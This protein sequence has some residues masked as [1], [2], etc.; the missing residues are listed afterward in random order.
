MR[1]VFIQGGGIGVDQEAAVRR[2]VAAAGA[3]IDW[4]T[5]HAGRAAVERGEPPLP[6]RLAD[7]VRSCGFALKTKLLD[8]P[9]HSGARANVQLRRELGLFASVRPLVSYA[10]L[11][12]RF[13][14]IDMLV[15]REITEDLYSAIEHEI[16][17]GVVQSIKVVTEA[18]CLRFFRFVFALARQRGRQSVH[19]IHKA[20]ILK[21][22][23]GLILDCFRRVAAEHPEIRPKELIVDNACMQLV[24][25]PQQFEVM[26]AGNLYGDLLSDLGAGLVG[27][28]AA[29]YGINH[30]DGVRVYESIHGGTIEVV[31]ADKANPLPLLLSAVELLRDL[32]QTG[33]ADRVKAAVQAVLAAGRVRTADLGGTAGTHDFTDA[34]I[35]ALG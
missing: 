5:I 18:A 29:S 23:D 17:P 22:A 11:P 34:V 3:E 8:A 13:P 2:V 20:N 35:A 10:G 1:V 27:G 30:G 31:G 16:V 7:A 6:P 4:L 24:S 25:R 19:C 21:K 33:P 32:G 14:D 28:V 26:A 12:L 15:V 9:P